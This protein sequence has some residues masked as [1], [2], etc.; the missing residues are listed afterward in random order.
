[1]NVEPL[2]PVVDEPLPCEERRPFVG[3]AEATHY[4]SP[5]ERWGLFRA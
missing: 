3:L 1:M 5:L 4:G 2:H